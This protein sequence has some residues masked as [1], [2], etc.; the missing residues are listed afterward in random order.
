[1][2]IIIKTIQNCDTFII[3]VIL[4]PF[5]NILPNCFL[6]FFFKSNSSASSN[7]KFMYSSN[8]CLLLTNIVNFNRYLV[9]GYHQKNTQKKGRKTKYETYNDSSFNSHIHLFIEPYLYSCLVLKKSKYQID[10]KLYLCFVF[11][12]ISNKSDQS[13]INRFTY[14]VV[15]LLFETS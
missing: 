9:Q 3:K 1:M 14:L 15:S 6:V 12:F 4:S 5:N 8:P 11:T 2:F 10:C 7:V 13:M